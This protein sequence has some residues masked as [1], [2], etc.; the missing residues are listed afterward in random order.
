MNNNKNIFWN[1]ILKNSLVVGIMMMLSKIIET[2]MLM[3]AASGMG[4][5]TIEMLVVFSAFIYLL[6]RYTKNY[7]TALMEQMSE[8]KEFTFGQGFRFIVM[9]CIISSIIITLGNY[10]YVH[11]CIGY[12]TYLNEIS[13]ALKQYIASAPNAGGAM[14]TIDQLMSRMRALPEPGILKEIW[15]GIW[16]YAFYGAFLGIIIAASLKKGASLSKNEDDDDI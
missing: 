12:Q 7:R 14:G 8:P 11:K 15:S 5:Y 16:S 10:I 13:N 9:L 1:S 3:N 2:K 6:V 4:L